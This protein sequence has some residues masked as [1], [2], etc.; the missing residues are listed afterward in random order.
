M[1]ILTNIPPNANCHD[2]ALHTSHRGGF[3]R[4]KIQPCTQIK[5]NYNPKKQTGYG[6]KKRHRTIIKGC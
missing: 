4:G 3:C 6:K 2:C 1:S 5:Y